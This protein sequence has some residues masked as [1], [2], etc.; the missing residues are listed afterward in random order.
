MLKS[1]DAANP[2]NESEHEEED[3]K[4]EFNQSANTLTLKQL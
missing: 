2:R 4:T 3:I 1:R